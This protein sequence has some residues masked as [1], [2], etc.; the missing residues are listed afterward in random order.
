MSED[1]R[2]RVAA[3]RVELEHHSRQYHVLDTPE[4]TDAEYTVSSASS[5]TLKP[6]IRSF[7]HR[8]LQRSALVANPPRTS[9][10]SATTGRCSA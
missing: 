3:L 9:R 2:D 5:S 10:R 7:R 4:I 6:P 8:I 1:A